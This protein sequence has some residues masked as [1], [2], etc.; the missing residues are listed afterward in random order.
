LFDASATLSVAT[1]DP[2]KPSIA[3]PTTMTIVKMAIACF[4]MCLF[5]GCLFRFGYGGLIES[6]T[7]KLNKKM[8]VCQI[9]NAS[10]FVINN[11]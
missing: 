4:M 11:L 7:E 8:Q 2:E 10:P 1:D 5:Q 9:K 6:S 3:Y